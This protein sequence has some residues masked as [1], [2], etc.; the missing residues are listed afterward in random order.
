MNWLTWPALDRLRDYG[1]VVA[2]VGLGCMMVAHG[3]P[4]LIDPSR[5][6]RLGAAMTHLGIDFMPA[7]WGG[8]AAISEV[9]G[10]ALVALGL[11]TRPAATFVV[12]TLAVAW[13]SHVAG[14]DPFRSWSHSAETGLGFLLFVFLGS[15]RFGIDTLLRRG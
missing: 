5:W 12:I 2:R 6:P 13:W 11:F 10:G 7:F 1:I 14:G 4:K 15:G 8:A 3:W 9:L